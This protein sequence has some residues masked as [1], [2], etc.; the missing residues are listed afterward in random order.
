VAFCDD[1]LWNREN[2]AEIVPSIV[3]V[4]RIIKK[5]EYENKIKFCRYVSIDDDPVLKEYAI[6]S[7]PETIVF[8]NGNVLYWVEGEGS[9]SKDVEKIE[10]L[11]MDAI[12]KT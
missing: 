1:E 8:V 6:R 11:L 12:G 4:K 9:V 3:A 2:N 7:L 10:Q 5:G